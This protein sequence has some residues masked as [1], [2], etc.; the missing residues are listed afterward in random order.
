M[1]DEREIR[2]CDSEPADKANQP[3][4][5]CPES[6][7]EVHLEDRLQRRNVVLFVLKWCLIYLAAPVLYVGFVQAGLCKRLGA[8]DFVANLPSAVFLLFAAFPMFMAW[9]VPQVRYLKTVVAIGYVVTAVSSALTA[10]VI[11]LPVPDWLRLVMVIGHGA[12]MAC[13]S[14]TALAFEWEILGRGI[15]ESRRGLLFACTFSL[16][17]LFAVIGSLGAQLV[18]NNEIFGWTPHF[19]G[20][21]RYPFS[22]VILYGASVPL[23]L[24]AAWLAKHYVV[25]P[26]AV[27]TRRKPFISGVFG[28]FGSFI[29]NRFILITCI[30]YLLVYS[31]TT[32]QNNMVL[33]TREMISLPED[34]FVGYQLAIRFGSKILGGLMLGWCLK[35][36]N[37]RMNLLVTGF[38]ILSSVVWILNANAF[39]GGGMLFL[40]AFGFIGAGELMGVYYPYY[41]LCLSPKSRMRRNMAF[42]MLLSAPVGFAPALFGFISDTWGLTT[43][44]GLSFVITAVGLILVA[45]ALPA[46]PR[47]HPEDLEA[48]DLE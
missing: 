42:V 8:S 44:F 27:E 4:E 35:R 14:G 10:A 38:L 36:T 3:Q 46:Q 45:T 34:T 11:W 9:A 37:P 26:P 6:E 19:W 31:G 7:V 1:S 15:S 17:P 23:M 32:I 28:G 30:A 21:I 12:V 5:G 39:F 22:Y 18:I 47:P 20:Q 41:V 43:S 40:G 33:Y 2:E 48:T 24:A 29:R 13:G 25:P 16:G